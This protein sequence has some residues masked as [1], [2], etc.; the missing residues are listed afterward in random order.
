MLDAGGLGV[1]LAEQVQVD[2]VVDG[3][4]LIQLG[5]DVHVVGVV[6][7]SAHDVGVLVHVV[8]QLLG[9]SSE[10]ED[11]TAIVQGLVLAVDL[12]GLGDVHEGVDVHLGVNAQVLQVG[13][14]DQS[15][16][17]VGHAAD[18]QLQ[19]GAV[20]DLRHDQVCHGARRWEA[21]SP[22]QGWR[23]CCPRRHRSRRQC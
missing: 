4:E 5:D 2:D 3:D 21:R 19:A 8:I 10:S 7:R 1:H 15:A 9:T 23:G 14:S 11:L 16:D 12:A 6:N 13:L 22:A 18:A 20:G 17:G